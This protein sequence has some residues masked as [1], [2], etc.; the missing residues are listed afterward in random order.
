[1]K[2]RLGR[3]GCPLYCDI[4]PNASDMLIDL[5][6][7]LFLSPEEYARY[8]GTEG[9]QITL[10]ENRAGR[11]PASNTTEPSGELSVGDIVTVGEVTLAVAPAGWEL[12]NGKLTEIRVDEHGTH[13]LPSRP[14]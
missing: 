8:K 6:I 3:I 11:S 12:V 10:N 7:R 1:M 4:G 14:R 5:T 9:L 2:V 13:P